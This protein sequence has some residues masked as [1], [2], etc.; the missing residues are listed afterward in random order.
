VNLLW[1]A[2]SGRRTPC[3]SKI[4]QSTASSEKTPLQRYG[5]PEC[6]KKQILPTLQARGTF[7]GLASYLPIMMKLVI[8]VVLVLP[9]AVIAAGLAEHPAKN[10]SVNGSSTGLCAR[11][12]VQSPAGPAMQRRDVRFQLCTPEGQPLNSHLTLELVV[13]PLTASFTQ[14]IIGQSVSTDSQGRFSFSYGGSTLPG[15]PNT[16]ELHTFLLD[17]KVIASFLLER[18]PGGL[19]FSRAPE[20]IA[21]CSTDGEGE[22]RARH[23]QA[24]SASLR[25]RPDGPR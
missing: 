14:G 10:L 5:Y 3:E 22:S 25:S 20:E 19:N 24:A 8:L 15:Q 4:P 11:I 21:R 7:A 1:S 13:E 17:G 2:A 18:G 9:S 6:M 23:C 16:Q 12:G